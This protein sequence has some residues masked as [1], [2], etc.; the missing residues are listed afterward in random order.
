M[1][2]TFVCYIRVSKRHRRWRGLLN[3]GK[4]GVHP[5]VEIPAALGPSG[6]S[7]SARLRSET[8]RASQ[9]EAAFAQPAANR[10]RP[11]CVQHRIFKGARW[12]QVVVV[13]G[14][15]CM[16]RGGHGLPHR[17]L[18]RR[19]DAHRGP[20]HLEGR[21]GRESIVLLSSASAQFGRGRGDGP[22]VTLR[23]DVRPPRSHS[24]AF[25][26]G[27]V[28]QAGGPGVWGAGGAWKARGRPTL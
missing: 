27:K 13:L 3:W 7:A 26:G 28:G 1:S 25:L 16:V 10:T 20:G 14:F 12:R 4:W 15:G 23:L 17:A 2:V 21:F 22:G 24:W 11:C 5:S 6:R 18:Q 19:Q 9:S 8:M